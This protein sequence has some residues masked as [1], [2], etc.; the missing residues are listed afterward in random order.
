MK[1]LNVSVAQI[2]CIDGAVEQ[3]LLHAYELAHEASKRGAELVLFPEFMPQGYR[4]TNE[5]WDAAEPFDG[6]TTNWL[7]ATARELNIYV[8]TSFLEAKN[9]HFVNTFAMADPSGKI[10]G[11]V[12]KRYS[13]MWEAYFFKGVAGDHIIETEFG[14]AGVGICFDNHTYK[15]ASLIS[16]AN[17]DI[18]LMPHSYCTPTVPNKLTTSD[19]IERLKSLPVKVARLY[20]E[21]TGAPVLM[22]N[23]SGNWD[24]PVPN[25]ILGS[26]KDFTFS[27]KSSIID[28]DGTFLA[29]LDDN[30][31]IGYGLVHLDPNLKN[32]CNIPKYSRYIYPGPVGREIIRLM[33][34]QGYMN[35]IF[36]RKRKRKARSIANPNIDV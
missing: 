34:F 20:N 30:E 23:K 17:P 18:I 35:Y 28:A 27:G 5:I 14:K 26:P 19:D 21:Y 7:C 22:C 4:L 12:R 16:K 6:P 1:T 9:G 3:N 15:V 32:C 24:S 13:S 29:K 2:T 10:A 8:G 36:S 25:K 33:E 31:A 11:V